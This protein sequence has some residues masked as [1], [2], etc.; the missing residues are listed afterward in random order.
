MTKTNITYNRIWLVAYPIILGSIAQNL[1]NFTDTAFLG[2]VGEIALGAGAIGGLFYLAVIMLG[3]GFGIGAQ[4]I[5]ARRLGQGR[6]KEI[7][8]VVIH[9]IIFLTFLAVIVFLLLKY[10]SVIILKYTID[11]TAIYN[12]SIDFLKIRAFGIFF[13][14]INIA[15]RSF[16]VGIAKTK[17]ITY[18]TIV[19]AAVNIFLD[20]VLIFGKMGM[21]EMGI[22]GAALA[23]VI[24]EISAMLYF[25]IYTIAKVDYRKYDLFCFS[26]FRLKKLMKIFNIS[27]PMM[28]QQFV[29]L[30]VW[31]V[32]FLFVEKI[33]EMALAV[34]NIIRSVYVIAMVPIWG[35]ATATNTLTSYL[36][37]MKRHDE[38]PS[39]IYKIAVLSFFGVLFIVS[40]GLFSPRMIMEIYT[41]QKDLIEV[42]A[43]ILYVVSL[44]ALFLSVGFVLLNGVSGTGKTNISLTIE[45]AVLAVYVIYTYV[46]IIEFNTDIIGAW[47]SEIVY[48]FLLSIVSWMYLKSNRWLKINI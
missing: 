39:L 10:G 17:V 18:T 16:Y 4:I 38:V 22:R 7:G 8:E 32:F 29:S 3:L 31:F 26:R 6:L 42:G 34:S 12:G 41:N 47:T 2:R 9:T 25:I 30:A 46:L 23:S 36:I 20:Y 43:P 1:I 37:G 13:A 33:G 14:F 40:M 28:V 15:F 5:I 27:I 21:P 19:L 44:G 45:L 48:G 11:S 24:A 35:F